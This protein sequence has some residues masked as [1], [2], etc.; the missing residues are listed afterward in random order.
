MRRSLARHKDRWLTML[1]VP[2]ARSIPNVSSLGTL[3]A[4]VSSSLFEILPVSLV[5]P[6]ASDTRQ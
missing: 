1:Q 4:I 5:F 3:Q 2:R 6:L